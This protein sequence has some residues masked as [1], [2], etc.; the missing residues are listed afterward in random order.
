M[1]YDNPPTNWDI[2]DVKSVGGDVYWRF[3]PDLGAS[4]TVDSILVWHW[5][6]QID[7]YVARHVGNHTLVSVDPLHLEPSLLWECCGKHGFIREGV[8]TSV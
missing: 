5:C 4:P 2:P 8:W 6:K 7:R 1:P 3:D